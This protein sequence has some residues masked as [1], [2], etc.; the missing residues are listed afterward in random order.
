MRGLFG[1][2]ALLL[3]AAMSSAPARAQ[4]RILSFDSMIRV[5]V[6]ASL[7]VTETIAVEALGQEI[8]RGIY[9]DFPTVYPQPDGSRPESGFEV[10]EVLR[11]GEPE[12]WFTE[13]NLDGVRVYF[14][15]EDVF[16]EPGRHVYRLTYRT[17]RQL[18]FFADHDELYWNVN[19][20]GWRFSVDK[21]SATVVLPS[22]AHMLDRTAYSGYIGETREDWRAGEDEEG[23]P[24]FE[25]TMAFPARMG[26]T[27][28][29]SFPKG[30]VAYP[31]ERQKLIW[32]FKD[33]LHWV[34]A[35]GILLAVLCYYLLVWWRVGRDPR[36][37]TVIPRYLSPDGISPS[38]ARYL[39]RMG[40]DKKSAGAATV[41]LAVRKSVV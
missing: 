13:G 24:V 21:V 39:A 14:G 20:N 25:S 22:G 28:V 8:E 5:N 2:A 12:P 7:T 6:D 29:V 31:T 35:A 23:N 32:L 26:L 16:L 11:N 27:I 10:V 37:G 15:Q 4:E 41:S 17:T 1:F 9:R 38:A 34:I 36:G 30:H 19:G 40:F 18:R 33:N 3:L